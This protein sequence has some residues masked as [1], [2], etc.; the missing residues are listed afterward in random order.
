MRI[1]VLAWGSLVWDR[2]ELAIVDHFKPNGPRL[3]LE[4]SRVSGDRR[5]TLVI[6]EDNGPL[7][8]T[9]AAESASTVLSDAIAAR[10]DR[11]SGV[12]PT[13]KARHGECSRTKT[14]PDYPF[15]RPSDF[16]RHHPQAASL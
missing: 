9:Y 16:G 3:S 4:F 8:D 1:A 11:R 5:L 13:S 6:D 15:P 2:R 7:C 14:R 10:A 12:I